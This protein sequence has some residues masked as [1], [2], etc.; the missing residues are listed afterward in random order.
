MNELETHL[1]ELSHRIVEIELRRDADALEALICDDYVG[2]DPSG[3]LIDKAVPGRRI[4]L[5]VN[6][7]GHP[8]LLC[9]SGGSAQTTLFA[10]NG[11]RQFAA[12]V[13][14]PEGIG[15]FSS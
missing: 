5:D 2:V 11:N 4:A 14:V 3:A 9:R 6:Q 1:L 15:I 13:S 7:D 10:G 12:G 8:D